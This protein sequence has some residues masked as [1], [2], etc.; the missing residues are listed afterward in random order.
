MFFRDP[1]GGSPKKREILK[2][3]PKSGTDRDRKTEVQSRTL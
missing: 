2:A 3:K 1:G